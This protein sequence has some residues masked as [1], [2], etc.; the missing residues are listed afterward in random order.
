VRKGDPRV[1]EWAASTAD[2]TE[3]KMANW[4]ATRRERYLEISTG[5]LKEMT[6]AEHLAGVM[7]EQ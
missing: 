1:D 2:V 4:T 3:G 6:Q 5:W 7:D